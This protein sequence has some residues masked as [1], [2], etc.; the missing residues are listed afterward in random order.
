[1]NELNILA[2]I[3]YLERNRRRQR[4]RRN[5]GDIRGDNQRDNLVYQ[6]K[7]REV[8]EYCLA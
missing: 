7:H 2:A 5:P 3:V 4:I 6:K 1:M 8:V